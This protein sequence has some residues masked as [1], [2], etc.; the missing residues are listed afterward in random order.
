MPWVTVP[1]SYAKIG[2]GVRLPSLQTTM[3]AATHLGTSFSPKP[4]NL[5]K[6]EVTGLGDGSRE[7]EVRFWW[8]GGLLAPG[9]SRLFATG[10]GKPTIAHRSAQGR[11]RNPLNLCAI[12]HA[13]HR[14][15]DSANSTESWRR[16]SWASDSRTA[17][18]TLLAWP[19]IA[20]KN[21]VYSAIRS[22]GA[23]RFGGLSRQ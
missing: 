22:H 17:L 7:I 5:S 16:R 1:Q 12:V 21:W 6:Y 2:E 14:H 13:Q 18:L 3:L 23:R 19:T 8:E 10:I 11:L 15:R 9:L 4:L 20:S